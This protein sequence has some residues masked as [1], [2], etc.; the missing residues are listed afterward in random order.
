MWETSKAASGPLPGLSGYLLSGLW[1]E[2]ALLE[3]LVSSS[4]T[5]EVVKPLVL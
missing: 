4:F 1:L 3:L 2:G 5:Y